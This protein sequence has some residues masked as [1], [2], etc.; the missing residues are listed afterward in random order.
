MTLESEILKRLESVKKDINESKK[1]EPVNELTNNNKSRGDKIVKNG[2]IIYAPPKVA[3]RILLVFDATG[4]MSPLWDSTRQIMNEMVKRITE[5]GNVKLKCIAYRDYCDGPFIFEKS[6]WY[7]EADPLINFIM[8]IRCTG[9]G[10]TPE[11]VED[12]L[13]LAYD[14]KEMVTRVILIGDAPPHSIEKAGI[15]AMNLKKAGRPVFAF[16]VGHDDSAREAFKHIAKLSDGAYGD[17]RDYNDLLDMI[18]VTIVHDIG[19]DKEVNKYLKR[20][21]TSEYV[22]TYSQ[23]LPSYKK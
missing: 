22:K 21:G 16:L 8:G 11:A 17:L 7:S 13:K 3:S 12:A 23:S 6:E 9:G 20:Y 15:Q 2:R 4:S 5:V 18:S 19:G 10:D 14:E 1:V